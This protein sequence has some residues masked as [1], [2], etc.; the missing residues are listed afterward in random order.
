[1]DFRGRAGDRDA[2][3]TFFYLFPFKIQKNIKIENDNYDYVFNKE[4]EESNYWINPDSYE[5]KTSDEEENL[6]LVINLKLKIIL[7]AIK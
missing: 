7:T 2:S 4:L 5:D 1:M 3:G 6:T